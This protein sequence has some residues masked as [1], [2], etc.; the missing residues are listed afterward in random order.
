MK[1]IKWKQHNSS[2]YML[3]YNALAVNFNTVAACVRVFAY[4]KYIFSYIGKKIIIKLTYVH[5]R[6]ETE[7]ILF[8]FL[9][10]S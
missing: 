10:F 4:I 5:N 9:Y 1:N 7:K 8:S 3:N 2:M 6:G